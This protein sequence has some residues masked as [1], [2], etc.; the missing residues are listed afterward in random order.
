NVEGKL[1]PFQDHVLKLLEMVFFKAVRSFDRG[2]QGQQYVRVEEGEEIVLDVDAKLAS[3]LHQYATQN[4]KA[5]GLDQTRKI[6]V[7]GFHPVFRVAPNGRLL[8]ELVAQFA[9]VNREAAAELGGI[10]FRGGCTLVASSTGAFRYLISKPMPQASGDKVRSDAGKM[11]FARQQD[12]L[13]LCD[14]NSALTPYLDSKEQQQRMLEMMNFANL[15]G[16]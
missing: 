13:H 5:L 10:P 14:M 1:P 9:Q 3:A 6:Q 4:A 8:I 7:R 16:G 12:Y 11:R 15:H 2:W